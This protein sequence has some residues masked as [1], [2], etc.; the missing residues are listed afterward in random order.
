MT[1]PASRYHANISA[2]HF[3][4]RSKGIKKVLHDF[5]SE[6][7]SEDKMP[8]KDGVLEAQALDLTVGTLSFVI[9]G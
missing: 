7:I 3:V 9:S 4:V 2:A 8:I 6:I 1:H 5:V